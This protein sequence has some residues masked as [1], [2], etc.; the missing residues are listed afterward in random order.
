MSLP[1]P[2]SSYI[3]CIYIRPR[4][5]LPSSPLH[6]TTTSLSPLPPLSCACSLLIIVASDSTNSSREPKIETETATR[7]ARRRT[8]PLAPHHHTTARPTSPLPAPRQQ[9]PLRLHRTSSTL[10]TS[11]C[12][13]RMGRTPAI[14]VPLLLA[15]HRRTCPLAP[16]VDRIKEWQGTTQA[17]WVYQA[18]RDDMVCRFPES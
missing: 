13:E 16:I 4:P 9:R 11:R 1:P 12:P 10:E 8:R 14:S 3:D 18:P 2:S 6:P 7:S 17:D 15:R 5:A